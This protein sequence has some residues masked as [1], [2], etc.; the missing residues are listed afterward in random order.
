MD[1]FAGFGCNNRY[2]DE[3]GSGF[4]RERGTPPSLILS[5]NRSGLWDICRRRICIET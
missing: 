4:A 2:V 5:Q 3:T 1:S